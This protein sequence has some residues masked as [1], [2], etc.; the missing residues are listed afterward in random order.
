ML[1][2]LRF[3]ICVAEYTSMV[4]P[5]RG[6]IVTDSQSVLKTLGGGDVDPQA[7]DEPIRIDGTTVVL[8]VL[9]PD[10]DVL[11]EIQHALLQLPGLTLQYIKAQQDDDTPYAQLPMFAHLNVDAD[12]LA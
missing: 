2:F 12:K 6:E 7:T 9:C 3:L 1:S 10:W 4:D 5:W 11:I 8:N